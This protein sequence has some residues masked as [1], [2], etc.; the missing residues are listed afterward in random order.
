VRSMSATLSKEEFTDHSATFCEDKVDVPVD[1]HP[2][3]SPKREQPCFCRHL[4]IDSIITQ[5]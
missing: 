2:F 4:R 3:T 5:P 1:G